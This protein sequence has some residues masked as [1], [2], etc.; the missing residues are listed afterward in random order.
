[1]KFRVARHTNNLKAITTFYTG[2]LGLKI[3]GSFEDHNTYNGVFLGL[4]G[5]DWHLELQH[6]AMLPLINRTKMTFLFSMPIL[7]I[8]IIACCKDLVI[9]TYHQLQL[10]TRIGM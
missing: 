4:Q 10:K 2:V 7:K 6:Q 8:I 1:M 5:L 9:T 3:F